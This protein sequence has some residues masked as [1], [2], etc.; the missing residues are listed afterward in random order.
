MFVK[1]SFPTITKHVH[2]PN[3]HSTLNHVCWFW[4]GNGIPVERVLFRGSVLFGGARDLGTCTE[5]VQGVQLPPAVSSAAAVAGL[6]RIV[7]I[8]SVWFGGL[9]G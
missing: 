5:W 7:I 6:V 4:I 8:S 9:F 2:P 3:E 1:N